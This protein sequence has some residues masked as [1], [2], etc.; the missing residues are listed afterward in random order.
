MG[1]IV[2]HSMINDSPSQASAHYAIVFKPTVDVSDLQTVRETYDPTA[3][4]IGPHLTLVFPI[5][6]EGIDRLRLIAHIAEV[7]ARIEPFRARFGDTTLSW[8]QWLFLIPTIGGENFVE[9]HDRLYAGLL[10]P[11]LRRDLP[12]APH[13]SLGHFA[14]EKEAPDLKNPSAGQLDTERYRVASAE[15]ANM[16]LDYEFLVDRI[17]LITVD[18]SFARSSTLREFTLGK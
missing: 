18:S 12:F 2:G 17:G 13:I 3:H 5:R 4:L 9:L 15:I 1:F 10:A 16:R 11:L 8:D 7:V 14:V 6:A